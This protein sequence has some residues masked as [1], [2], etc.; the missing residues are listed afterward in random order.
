MLWG[1]RTCWRDTLVLQSLSFRG[2]WI[3]STLLPL[4]SYRYFIFL[5]FFLLSSAVCVKA[6][7]YEFINYFIMK[8]EL[9]SI[10]RMGA[11][12]ILHVPFGYQ[13]F[14]LLTILVLTCE[15][16]IIQTIHIKEISYALPLISILSSE[17]CLVDVRK[18]EPVDGLNRVNKVCV[19]VCFII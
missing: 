4:S 8:E 12:L 14:P 7:L 6:C 3:S 17:T 16:N 10:Q 13:V 18:M 9:W 5:G 11:G 1:A 19:Y 15:S 2:S